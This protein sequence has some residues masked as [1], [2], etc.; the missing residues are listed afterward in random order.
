MRMLCRALA[1]VVTLTS[2]AVV[3]SYA[4]QERFFDGRRDFQAAGADLHQVVVRN[5]KRVVLTFRHQDVRAGYYAGV[6]AYIDTTK[7]RPGPE[8]GIGGGI[9]GGSDWQLWRTRRWRSVSE[10]INCPTELNVDYRN[11]ISQFVIPRRCIGFPGRVRVSVVANDEDG[12]RDW[13]PRYHRF[14]SWVRR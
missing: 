14:Y 2:I 10:P 11:D 1:L 8:Y 9:G 12:D 13:A 4:D 7:R 6:S 5:E 3:P